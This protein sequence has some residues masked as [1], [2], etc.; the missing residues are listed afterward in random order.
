[1]ERSK[2]ATTKAM[3]TA[4]PTA[5]AMTL[6]RPGFLTRFA[7]PS[8]TDA[9]LPLHSRSTHNAT[10]GAA[11]ATARAKA[12]D[13]PR[14]ATEPRCDCQVD[15]PPWKPATQERATPARPRPRPSAP[16]RQPTRGAR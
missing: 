1:M 7:R 4:D 9:F 13:V 8:P 10:P 15:I 5:T 11:K 6:V 12:V 3:A 16:R 2:L 14:R